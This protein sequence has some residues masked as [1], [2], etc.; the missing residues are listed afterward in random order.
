MKKKFITFLI[1]HNDEQMLSFNTLNQICGWF[2][3]IFQKYRLNWWLL[4]LN[5]LDI[6]FL[7]IK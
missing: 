2:W 6:L 4:M 3:N 7:I 1:K 5:F